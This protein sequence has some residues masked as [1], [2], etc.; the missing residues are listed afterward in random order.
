MLRNLPARHK[1]KD[2]Q[3]IELF[4]MDKPVTAP[5]ISTAG[6][7]HLTWLQLHFCVTAPFHSMAGSVPDIVIEVVDS[8]KQQT[9]NQTA[10]LRKYSQ[11]KQ[12]KV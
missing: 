9:C 3:G 4:G 2:Y 6:S 11:I 1:I 10:V 8:D 5:P 7:C 12:Q